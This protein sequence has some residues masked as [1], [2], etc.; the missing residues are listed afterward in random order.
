MSGATRVGHLLLL[1]GALALAGCDGIYFIKGTIRVNPSAVSRIGGPSVVCEGR[2]GPLET[3][4]V[5]GRPARRPGAAHGATL[6][7]A[8]PGTEQVFELNQMFIGAHM[9]TR[10]HAYAWLAPVPRAKAVCKAGE[11]IK[12]VDYSTLD[13][14]MSR[15]PT[16]PASKRAPVD[17]PCGEKPQPGWPM[18]QAITFD[19][20]HVTW[21][22]NG[23]EH[24]DLQLR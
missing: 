24:R 18:D 22:A 11:T 8:A 7:C 23:T 16:K 3:S 21:D 17:Y 2:G 9:P 13:E 10:A 14:L 4:A 5:A 15:D 19:P 20:D 1:T 12:E 6:F